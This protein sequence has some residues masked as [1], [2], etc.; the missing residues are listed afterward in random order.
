MAKSSPVAKPFADP[1]QP[2]TCSS[3]PLRWFRSLADGSAGF[4]QRLAWISL[5]VVLLTLAFAP[6]YQFYLA[7]FALVPWLL[8]AGSANRVTSAF[9][10]GWVSGVLFFAANLWWLWTASIAGTVVLILYFALY[11]GFAASLARGLRLIPREPPTRPTSTRWGSLGSVLA[12]SAVWVVAEWLR[13]YTVPGFAWMPL[14]NSQTPA[15]VLCQVADL[16]GPWIIGFWVVAINAVLACGWVEGLKTPRVVSAGI[17]VACL[18]LFTGVYGAWRIVSTDPQPGLTATV[19]QSNIPHL[20][21]GARSLSDEEATALLLTTVQAGAEAAGSDLI[22]LPEAAFP[23]IND[24]TRAELARAP[25]GPFLETT[26]RQLREL[27]TEHNTT[28]VIGANAVLDWQ[29]DGAARVG[30][31]ICN[32]AFLISPDPTRPMERYDKTCLVPFSE[33]MPFRDGPDWLHQ[34]AMRIAADRA[35]QPLHAGSADQR[36]MFTLTTKKETE[37]RVVVPICLENIDPAFIA[38]L[39]RDS[40]GRAKRADVIVNLSNDGWFAV[41]E[42]HQHLQAMPLRCIENRTPMVRSSNTGISALIDSTGRLISSVAAGV[43]GHASA[44]VPLDH[45]LTFYTRFGDLFVAG[46]ALLLAIAAAVQM[47]G[48]LR[49]RG[50]TA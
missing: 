4:G 38:T 28:L 26:Y 46:S 15:L 2:V 32:S 45:R 9:F 49:Q 22:V 24:E 33:R 8:V 35:A 6:F 19:V 39:I 36:S 34:I 18:L 31:R 13:C 7:W 50:A 12:I 11:W 48:A 44:N 37:L 3:Q 30:T 41:Q 42:R 23:P 43:T 16:G 17:A 5:S 1:R 20:P 47:H 27:A 29:S 25:I 21:G 10:W 14:G 40:E